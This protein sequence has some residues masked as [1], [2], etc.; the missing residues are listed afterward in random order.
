MTKPAARN[1]LFNGAAAGGPATVYA[2]G[3][4]QHG[5]CGNSANEIQTFNKV[6]PVSATYAEGDVIEVEI[7]VTAHHMGFFEFDLCTDAGQ[8]SEA[9]FNKHRLTLD[10]CYCECSD[11]S[12]NCAEC[13]HCRRYWKAWM[14]DE[15]LWPYN[16]ATYNTPKGVRPM[17]EGHYL[18]DA[19]FIARLSLPLGTRTSNGVLRWHWMS[20]N[21]CSGT[22]SQPEEFWNCADI[23]IRDSTGSAGPQISFD[24]AA[25]EATKPQNIKDEIKSQQLNGLAV[26]CTVGHDGKMLVEGPP[27]EYHCGTQCTGNEAGGSYAFCFLASEGSPK[28]SDN[29]PSPPAPPPQTTQAM[30]PAPST[31]I[32]QPT[33]VPTTPKPLPTEAPG[34]EPPTDE[35]S[36]VGVE[37]LDQCSNWYFQCVGHKLEEK[38]TQPGQICKDN[39]LVPATECYPG[40]VP[41]ASCQEDCH[42]STLSESALCGQSSCTDCPFCG[43]T[44][45]PEPVPTVSPDQ[46]TCAAIKGNLNGCTDETCAQCAGG[47]EWWPCNV[48]PKCCDC[49]GSLQKMAV[50]PP[51]CGECDTCMNQKG[52]CVDSGKAWCQLHFDYNWCGGPETFKEVTRYLPR[53]D[54]MGRPLL[55]HDGGDSYHI[56]GS[57]GHIAYHSQPD[58]AHEVPVQY[59]EIAHAGEHL[60]GKVE[61]VGWLSVKVMSPN[62]ERVPEVPG[63]VPDS[64]TNH[65]LPNAEGPPGAPGTGANDELLDKCGISSLDF[66]TA[67]KSTKRK[68]KNCIE[69]NYL[70]GFSDEKGPRKEA[71]TALLP[72]CASL[73]SLVLITTA[74][75]ACRRKMRSHRN[76]RTPDEELMMAE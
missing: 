38:S 10:G 63:L 19:K 57:F 72:L 30:T 36:T 47:Y 70:T 20:T 42:H 61:S 59:W 58:L 52:E 50:S 34:T 75:V 39:S 60:K 51:A 73:A 66:A 8:L 46:V 31:T 65:E 17:L 21:S 69:L 22:Y 26:G 56:P 5:M 43:S 13:D 54:F 2:G 24:N 29:T 12:T 15:S 18:T 16:A 53:Y 35:C 67:R 74:A 23:I 45:T 71:P 1:G 49:T 62:A 37:C 27:D 6:G 33:I 4:Y 25:L 11:G 9:C 68:Y 76:V 64:G 32:G 7:T 55:I 3:G 44:T 41:G 14:P 48:N 40:G 28:C